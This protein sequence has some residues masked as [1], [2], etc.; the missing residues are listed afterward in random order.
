MPGS[1]IC[2]TGRGGICVECIP[3]GNDNPPGC[4]CATDDTCH[5]CLVDTDCG[6]GAICLPDF[7]C[8]GGSSTGSGSGS[9]DNLLYA[10]P[11][12]TGD[13]SVNSKCSL[14]T[15]ISMVTPMKHVIELDAGT[16]AEGPIT[17][18]QS[19]V[20]IGPSPGSGHQYRDPT[21]PS[22]R[23][24]ITP[25]ANAAGAVV[26]V[27]G[28]T[29]ALFE[30][31][32]AGSQNDAGIKCAAATLEVYHDIIRDN[33]KEGITASGCP[34]TI[35]R[36]VFTKNGTTG[37][38]YEGLY[39]DNC[40]PVAVRNNFFMGNG[41]TTSVKGAVHFHGTTV[42]DFRFNS[43]GFNHAAPDP[44]TGPHP[45]PSIGGV[46]C[47][48]DMINARDNIVSKNDTHDWGYTGNCQSMNSYIAGDPHFTSATDLHLK[49]DSPTPAV[50]NNTASDCSYAH[51]YDI[52][53]DA[54]P[55]GGV[56]DLGADESR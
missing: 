50:V 52:D 44:K 20:L 41:N 11:N 5:E 23:A 38:T 7:T 56:C 33:P 9:T 21:D 39:L 49:N 2:D 43:V 28:G 13:C 29:V 10:T 8:V 22:G 47:E 54:R 40:S 45:P 55:I 53:F 25:A 17:I 51:G 42:G 37:S 48:S 4:H 1:L 16:Y 30:V 31:T 26:S 19:M 18:A 32:V 3:G 14:K 46:L 6:T 12:G 27:T 24:V 35:E 34:M 15:A 36:S